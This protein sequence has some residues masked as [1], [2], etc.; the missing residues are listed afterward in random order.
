MPDQRVSMFVSHKI[1]PDRR[2]AERIRDILQSRTERLDV[3][4]SE[5]IP[6]GIDWEQWI[7]ENVLRARII[8]VILPRTQKVSGWMKTEIK[9]FRE[10]VPNGQLITLKRQ[11]APVPKFVSKLQAIDSVEEEIA[12]KFLKPLYKETTFT[13]VKAALNARVADLDLARDAEEIADA[14]AGVLPTHSETLGNSLI[15]ET[16]ELDLSGRFGGRPEGGAGESADTPFEGIQDNPR[17][18][19]IVHVGRTAC[20][21]RRRQRQR[22]V[23]G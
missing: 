12:Q 14:V 18:P 7:R 4:I 5:H 17:L 22:D 13:G 10:Q 2:A 20:T 19:G 6:S 1:D 16:A 23:L 11:G 9:A 21:C 3:Q 15:V 8:L